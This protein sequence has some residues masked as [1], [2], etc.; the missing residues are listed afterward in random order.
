MR[1]ND[2]K[3]DLALANSG[4][5]IGQAADRAGISRQRYTT[6]LNQKR[7][8]PQAAGKIAKGV[9]VTVEQIIEAEN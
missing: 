3:F 9:G 5:T 8:T 6:I 7:V 2:T 1:I 4:L